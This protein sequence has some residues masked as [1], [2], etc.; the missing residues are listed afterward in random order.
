[1]RKITVNTPKLRNTL[2]QELRTGLY[3]KRVVE[4]KTFYNRKK[5]KNKSKNYVD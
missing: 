4:P 5:L 1:M 2:V 3:R